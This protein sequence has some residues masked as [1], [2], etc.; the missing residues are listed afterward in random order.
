MASIAVILIWS[1]SFYFFRIFDE[2]A[3]MIRM[4]INI[5]RKI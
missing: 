4:I 2:T 5:L 3:P 1:K